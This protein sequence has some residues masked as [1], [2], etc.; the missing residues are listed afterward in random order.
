IPRK[1]AGSE[2]STIDALMVASSVPSVVLDSTTHLYKGWSWSIRLRLRAVSATAASA[3]ATTG[4]FVISVSVVIKCR[5]RIDSFRLK[6]H[7]LAIQ[8][9]HEQFVFHAI[10]LELP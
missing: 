10:A 5:L 4:D 6:K 2:I 7:I 3:P 8:T 1:I 9:I